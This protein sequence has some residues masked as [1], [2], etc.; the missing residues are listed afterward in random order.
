M[1][2]LFS[3]RTLLFS[4]RAPLLLAVIR[5]AAV[6]L[7]A[8]GPRSVPPAGATTCRAPERASSDSCSLLAAQA[9]SWQAKAEAITAEDA[10]AAAAAADALQ[11][12]T[13]KRGKYTRWFDSPYINDILAA[14]TRTGGAPAAVVK[15]HVVDAGAEPPLLTATTFQ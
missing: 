3:I 2:E 9:R 12:P 6:F 13:A 10:L 4:L 14:Y 11:L 8:R 15:D 7:P 5:H 1:M